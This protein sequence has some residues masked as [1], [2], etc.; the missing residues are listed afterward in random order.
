MATSALSGKRLALITSQAFSIINFRAPLIRD[1]TA[2]GAEVF[3]FAPD[4]D[5]YTLNALDNLCVK[6]IQTPFSRA[7]LNPLSDIH[8]LLSLTRSLKEQGIDITFSYFV[9][10]VIYG[11]LAARVAGTA[12]N[13]AMIEG[14]GYIFSND[15]DGSVSV[16]KAIL[17]K[18]V[19][20]LYRIGLSKTDAVF[21]LNR[22]DID[23]F[24]SRQMVNPLKATLIGGIGVQLSD[25]K[26]SPPPCAPITFLL[27]AR[28]LEHKG[29]REFAEAARKLNRQHPTVR[30]VI[31]GSPDLNPAS[32]PESDLRAWHKE[33]IIHW[34]EHVPDVRSWLQEASV[35][36]LPS[37]Y[38]EGVPR[39]IQEA[40]ATGRAIITT[41]MPGC[42]DTIVDGESGFLVRPRS[43][44][45]L[46]AAM[47]AFLRHPTLITRM[48]MAARRRAEELFDARRANQL[49]IKRME[50]EIGNA[51]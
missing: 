43:V 47:E 15:R 46:H 20:M 9:K 1:W 45:S 30:C 28:L 21:F 13:F 32:V 37:W 5:D 23:L 40:M 31:L 41:D 33:G 11:G 14:A 48:G 50:L 10:P 8:G 12:H 18:L 22:D 24:T 27:A 39:S 7:G 36:V 51:T 4:F 6:A 19:S 34:Q 16:R 44:S 3:A 2:R 29:V 26:V 35:F 25:Y 17:R 38:R 49:I 42:R